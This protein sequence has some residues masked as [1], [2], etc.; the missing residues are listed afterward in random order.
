MMEVDK[1][2]AKPGILAPQ[3]KT[4]TP[5]VKGVGGGSV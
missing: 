3:S 2:Q 4:P 1:C 5:F